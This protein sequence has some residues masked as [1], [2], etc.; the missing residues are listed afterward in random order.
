VF[1]L[2]K[3]FVVLTQPLAWVVALLAVSL[4][5]PRRAV[6]SRTL[7]GLALGLLLL[8]GWLPL[9]DALIRNLE[10]HYAE[11]SPAAQLQGYVGMVVLGG[12]TDAGY[13]AQDHTQP[14]LNSAAERI[15]APLALLHANPQLRVIYTGGDGSLQRSGP[16]E[17][18]QARRFFEAVGVSSPFVQYEAASR[19][20]HENAMLS[21]QLPGVDIRQRWLLVTSAWHMPRA[22]ATFAQ[23]GWN[24]TPYPVD[25]RTG[26]NT[27]WTAYSL[28]D[29]ARRWQ[30]ALH[31][32][33]GIAAY[34]V[35]GRI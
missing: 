25:F 4:L 7:A 1:L 11:M 23:A 30:L 10:S 15:T 22:M 14:V 35:M 17:A 9:P 16:S 3:L 32:L 26:S 34:R 31:E 33:L 2:S 13:V 6:P 28:A 5:M 12:S 8:L 29:G 20:T 19:T 21:A 27:P 24:V 18:E